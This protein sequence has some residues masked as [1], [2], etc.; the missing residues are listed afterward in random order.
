MLYLYKCINT[1]RVCARA[2][3]THRQ[4]EAR[5]KEEKAEEGAEREWGVV[6]RLW[7]STR[8]QREASAEKG[9]AEGVEGVCRCHRGCR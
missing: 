3:A 7:T 9:V 6:H 2:Q 8:R 1:E 4:R 5:A